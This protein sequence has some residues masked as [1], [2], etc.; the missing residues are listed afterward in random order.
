[1]A[2]MVAA[3]HEFFYPW[4]MMNAVYEALKPGGR[5]V[6]VEYRGEDDTIEISNLHKLTES[7]ARK[8]MEF[9]GFEYRTTRDILPQQ[10][11]MVF[12]K[13]FD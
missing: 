7:Q 9:I 12:Q 13:P 1:L 4:E 6:V 8:E 5:V 2:L 11:F 10:H 3:Y